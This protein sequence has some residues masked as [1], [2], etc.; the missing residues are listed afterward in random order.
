[1]GKVK[2]RNMM[3][4]Q[5]ARRET[6]PWVQAGYTILTTSTTGPQVFQ[7]QHWNMASSENTVRIHHLR[8]YTAVS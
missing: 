5:L 8:P 7:T 4:P 2:V 1:M 3:A 6:V